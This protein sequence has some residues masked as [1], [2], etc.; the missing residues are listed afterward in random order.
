ARAV[1]SGVEYEDRA[2]ALS[3]VRGAGKQGPRYTTERAAAGR[4][5]RGRCE[6]T[7][8]AN[9]SAG[10]LESPSILRLEFPETAADHLVLHKTERLAD[11]AF[12]GLLRQTVS[13]SAR[14]ELF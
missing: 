4:I 10:E 14:R 5:E 13:Q 6:V 12:Y 11:A 9:H 2:E 1:A 3:P 7:V 8:P